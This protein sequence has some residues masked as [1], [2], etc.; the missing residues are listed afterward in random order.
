MSDSEH[1]VARSGGTDSD[2]EMV[3]AGR[4]QID[5]RNVDAMMDPK[6]PS[7]HRRKVKAVLKKGARHALSMFCGC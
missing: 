4:S 2:V 3:D 1:S 6:N 7:F 5:I